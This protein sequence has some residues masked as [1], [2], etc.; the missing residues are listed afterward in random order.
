M[1]TKIF[2]FLA[3]IVA[4]LSSCDLEGTNNR[5]PQIDFFCINMTTPDTLAFYRT[6]ESGVYRL[7]TVQQ[8][9]TLFFGIAFY[10]FYNN[11]ISFQLTQSDT[12]V[13]QILLPTVN[14]M[15]S[16]FVN[17]VSDYP[18]GK[19]IFKNNVNN[20]YMPLR[21]IAKEASNNVKLT[22]TLISDAQLDSFYGSNSFSFSLKTPIVAKPE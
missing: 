16:I 12:T 10:G 7:D 1:K 22:F 2:L 21:Y 15:D 11:L 18:K 13:T 20:A 3:A 9:D 19:F 5:T 8:G 6:D 14:S 17:S 4:I